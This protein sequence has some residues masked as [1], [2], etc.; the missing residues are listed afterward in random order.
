M[1]YCLLDCIIAHCFNLAKEKKNG[2]G[3]WEIV[4]ERSV[5]VL[6]EARK[7]FLYCALGAL[8]E[9][10]RE[11]DGSDVTLVALKL[12]RNFAPFVAKTLKLVMN[13]APFPAK[14]LHLVLAKS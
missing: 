4:S 6:Q 8:G 11:W 1:L 2:Q 14:K 12:A 5:S 10:E 3:N 9:R 13:F 7:R